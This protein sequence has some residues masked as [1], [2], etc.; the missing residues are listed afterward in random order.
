M[1]FSNQK[2]SKNI[3]RSFNILGVIIVLVGLGFLWFKLDTLVLITAGVFALYIGIAQF[4][5]LCFLHFSPENGKVTIQY[6]Q[7]ISFLKKKY[8]TIEFP[9]QVLVNFRIERSLGFAD[10][11]IAIKTKRGIAEYPSISL[12]ALNRVE[13]EQIRSALEEII[14]NNKRGA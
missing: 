14:R 11:D 2:R 10:L 7:V 4:L 3:K 13:V 8:E 1:E 6:Y 9:H 12:A 5:N